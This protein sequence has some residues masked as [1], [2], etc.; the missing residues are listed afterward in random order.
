MFDIWFSS[1][2][3]L[4]L[5]LGW[6][7][8]DELFKRYYLISLLVIGYDIIF[9]WVVRMYFFGLEFIGK[10]LFEIVLLY[11]LVCDE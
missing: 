2:I 7:V 1:G 5:F 3:V 8:S 11:G 6:L 4:F 9:F 10:K